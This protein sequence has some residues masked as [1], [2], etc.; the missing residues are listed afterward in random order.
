M[1]LQKRGYWQGNRAVLLKCSWTGSICVTQELVRNA[2]FQTSLKPTGSE[3]LGV[4]PSPVCL[5][6]PPWVILMDTQV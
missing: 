2:E 3:S 6:K 4:R 5:N 1:K